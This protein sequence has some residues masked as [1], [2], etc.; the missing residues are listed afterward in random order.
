MNRDR[1]S[2]FMFH[3]IQS[4]GSKKRRFFFDL[5]NFEHQ[6]KAL[7][8]R[9]GVYRVGELEDLSRLES[10]AKCLL[11][12]DDGLL[13]HYEKILPILESLQYL[14]IFFIPTLPL[15]ES[16]L[17][18]VH[19]IHKL[20][21]DFTPLQ[22][23]QGIN[24]SDR[25]ELELFDHL[26]PIYLNYQAPDL[27]TRLRTLINFNRTY[28]QGRELLQKY[29]ESLYGHHQDLFAQ[30]WYISKENVG[31]ILKC[32]ML[33]GNHT[34]D[35]RALDSLSFPELQHQIVDSQN[36]FKQEFDFT[37]TL[38]SYPFGKNP[39]FN[40][41][42]KKLLIESGIKYGFTAKEG[43]YNQFLKS[44]PTMLPRFD[45]NFIPYFIQ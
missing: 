15:R 44:A 8:E 1:G 40:L 33:V 21:T 3:Y 30:E 41:Q 4:G 35:H 45:C 23:A 26:D 24:E 17:L 19:A 12:F 38:L 31:E 34:V 13:E 2:A 27:F 42:T 11:T 9:F 20:E 43:H 5:D 6:I 32:G 18:N 36:Y 16:H 10:P 14:G 7:D 28:D 25:E 22:F 39:N 37:P 29:F